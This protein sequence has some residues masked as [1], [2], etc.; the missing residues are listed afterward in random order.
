M[1]QRVREAIEGLRAAI[2]ADPPD[3]PPAFQVEVV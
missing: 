2:S 3:M 1:S